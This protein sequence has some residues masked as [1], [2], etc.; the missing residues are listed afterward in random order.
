MKRALQPSAILMVMALLSGIGPATAQIV[1]NEVD[2]D[3]PGTDTAE[4]VELYDGG[5]GNTDLTG[6]VLVFYNGSDDASYKAFDLDG[7]STGADGFFVLCGDAANVANCDLDVSPNTNLIQNGADAVAL[8]TGDATDFPNDTPVTTTNLLDAVVY[9]TDDGDDAGLLVLLN[10]AQPQVNENGGGDKDNE[11]NARVPDGGTARNTDT[12]LQQAPTPGATNGG[13]L[14]FTLVI[15]EIDYD[16]PS[17]DTAEFLEL[18]NTGTAPV[19]LGGYIVELVNGAGGGATVYQTIILPAVMLA[20]G[21]Y[22]V[23]CEDAATVPDCDL[24]AITSIQNGA[25]DAVGLRFGSTLVDAVSYEGNTGA[26]Y[27]EGAGTGLSDSSTDDFLAIARFPDGVDTDVNNV[28][29]SRR[30]ITPG[31]ENLVDATSCADPAADPCLDP[32]T[33]P[34]WDGVFVSNGDGT[35]LISVDAPAG[36][37]AVEL[38]DPV[39]NLTLTAV[40]DPGG[41]ATF[42]GVGAVD[43]E[44]NPRRYE[45][46]SGPAPAAVDMHVTAPLV[47]SS[48]FFAHLTDV[49]PRT[50]RVDPDLSLY[51]GLSRGATATVF[52]LE[53]NYPN[54]FRSATTIRF[55]L[56]AASVVNITVYDV[57]GRAVA[58][59]AHGA[60]EAGTHTLTW[61]GRDAAG[62]GLPGGVYFYRIEAGS[63]TR[64]RQMTV[65]R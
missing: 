11:A 57:L 1:I 31:K 50:L 25:P 30:C 48:F 27:T 63:F 28:D 34:F 24:D 39:T 3:T 18:K 14:A 55:S 56:P 6:L 33:V 49:C 45:L 47:A 65:V 40:T 16:Q 42:V 20:A 37:S 60:Y 61:D 38:G 21:D 4:F 22:Y 12:Y 9:D 23:I 26:P 51:A 41:L 44:G 59:P 43:S 15:N 5:A 35:G 32:G 62:V 29:L 7:T 10:A 54:P 36:F 2:A 53:P 17:T 19:D 58:M 13:S 8:F 64:T 46:D 52:A